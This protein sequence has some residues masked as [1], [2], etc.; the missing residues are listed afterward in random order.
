MEAS[1]EA[2]FKCFHNGIILIVNCFVYVPQIYVIFSTITNLP[3]YAFSTV[4]RQ[5]SSSWAS[6]MG[7]GASSITSRPVLFLGNAM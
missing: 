6:S 1:P 5:S 3:P 2:R 7:A 4:R